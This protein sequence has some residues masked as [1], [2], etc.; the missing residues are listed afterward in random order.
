[1]WQMIGA[2]EMGAAAI[3]A[4]FVNHLWIVIES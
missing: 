4:I 3:R 2:A 1:M